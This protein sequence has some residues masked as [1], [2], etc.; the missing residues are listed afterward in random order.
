MTSLDHLHPE[1]IRELRQMVKVHGAQ[2][3]IEAVCDIQS[4]LAHS[5][6]N[7]AARANRCDPYDCDPEDL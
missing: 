5:R 4:E 3:L 6:A 1:T 2:R 7:A